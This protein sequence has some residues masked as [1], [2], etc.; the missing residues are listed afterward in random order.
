MHCKVVL[1]IISLIQFVTQLLSVASTSGVK[2]PWHIPD[3]LC[4][5]PKVRMHKY[6]KTSSI[7]C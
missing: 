7:A 1:Y 5:V 6:R 3:H 2:Q 4:L